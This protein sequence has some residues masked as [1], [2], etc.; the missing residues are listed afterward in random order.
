[1]VGVH[2]VMNHFRQFSR[3]ICFSLSSSFCLVCHPGGEESSRVGVRDWKYYGG[4]PEGT[5]F[6]A[7]TQINRSNVSQL[8]IAWTYRTGEQ[9]YS[10]PKMANVLNPRTSPEDISSGQ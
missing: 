7:L 1:M 5:R 3:L 10:S 6:S 9:R 8:K 2:F 4:D